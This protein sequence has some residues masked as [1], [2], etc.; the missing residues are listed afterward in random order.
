MINKIAIITRNMH[1]GG[2]ERVIAQLIKYFY[3]K[4]IKIILIT[5]DKEEIFYELPKDIKIY[6]I[7]KQSDNKVLDRI[8]RYKKVREI[9]EKNNVDLVLSMPEDIGIYV[10]P[11][12]IGSKIPVV[13]SERNNPWVM[14]DKMIT[15]F[16][17]SIFYNFV[18]GVIFQTNMAASFFNKKIQNKGVVLSNPVDINRIPMPYLGERNNEIVAVGRLAPQKNFKLLIS[19][20]EEFQKHNSKYKL[21]IYGE[22]PLRNELEDYARKTLIKGSYEFPGKKKNI[23]DIINKSAMFILSSDYEGVP[24]VLIEALA[25]GLPVIST[26]CPS[27]GPRSL[28]DDGGNGILIPV[29]DKEALVNAMNKLVQENYNKSLLNDALKFRNKVGDE[30][31]Y[32]KWLDY[33]NNINRKAKGI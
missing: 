29:N 20:F 24:N 3:L 7:G 21:V 6:E 17:R 30:R 25:M 14:P 15:R 10:I 22:G 11:A 1:G 18:D 8:Y 13:V 31:I 23:L 12:L 28:M 16:M 9:S 26:D 5:I 33:L 27:G 32:E 2:A 19:A 4:K